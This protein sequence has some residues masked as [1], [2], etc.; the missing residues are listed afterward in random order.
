[1]EAL[2]NALLPLL[3]KNMGI[4]LLVEALMEQWKCGALL[5]N[6]V[7]WNQTMDRRSYFGLSSR[8]W[9]DNDRYVCDYISLI[10]IIIKFLKEISKA[11][12]GWLFRECG[13]CGSTEESLI[14]GRRGSGFLMRL[15]D[16][17]GCCSVIDFRRSL[18]RELGNGTW[19]SKLPTT[20]FRGLWGYLMEHLLIS[21]IILLFSCNVI[22]KGDVGVNAYIPYL[23]SWFVMVEKLSRPLYLI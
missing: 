15:W 3:K 21:L 22:I 13:S 7:L 2:C 4:S 11:Q 19:E 17:L 5:W 10:S 20:T 18:I 8:N 12:Y 9:R 16:R 1:M 6:T 23:R 14:S